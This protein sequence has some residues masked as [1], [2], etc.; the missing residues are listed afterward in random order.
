MS[1]AEE[2][3]RDVGTTGA[4]PLADEDV[5]TRVVGGDVALFEILVRRYN[6]RVYRVA[7]AIVRDESEAEDVMQDS[8]VRAFERLGQLRHGDR[9]APW[10]TRIA[11]REARRRRR[12]RARDVPLSPVADFDDEARRV[13]AT[14]DDPERVTHRAE[15]IRALASAVDTLSERLRVVFMLRDVEG[16]STEDTAV[17]LGISHEAVR[18]R[19]HRSRSALRAELERQAGLHRGELFPFYDPRCDRVVEAVLG[20]IAHR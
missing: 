15:L 16:M 19:L 17:S 13:E 20:R 18:V 5:V 14:T 3:A 7:R 2:P 12:R 11:A 9:F 8:Y 4:R 10:L 1:A 6:R